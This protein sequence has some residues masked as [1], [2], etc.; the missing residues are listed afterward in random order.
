MRLLDRLSSFF[1]KANPVWKI[2]VGNTF[3]N[4]RFTKIRYD[5]L[6]KESYESN[7]VAFAS[8]N[9]FAKN[10][11]QIEFKLFRITGETKREVI[12]HPLLKLIRRPNMRQ[13]KGDFLEA[14]ASYRLLSGNPFINAV[15]VDPEN[16][17]QMPEE[18]WL[19]RPDRTKIVPGEF[20]IQGYL[21]ESNGVKKTFKCDQVTGECNILH[22]KTFHPTDDFYGLSA[23]QAGAR[24]IDI[25]NESVK[26]NMNF[27]QNGVRPSGALVYA[28]KEG[29]QVLTD[30]QFQRLEEQ[31]KVQ[32]SG[33]ANSGRPMILEG[34]MDWRQLSMSPKDIDFI[35]GKN[36]SARDIARIFGVPPLLLNIPGDNT[37]NNMKEAKLG[38]WE[39]GII[40]WAK[41][42]VDQL[43][44]WLTPRYGEDLRLELNLDNISALE[45]RRE[46]KFKKANEAAFLSYN[47][48]RKITGFDDIEGG[49]Q[50]FVPANLIPL[51]FNSATG[52]NG[53]KSIR[54]NLTIKA[55]K[56]EL[57]REQAIQL[58]LS[59]ALE[60]GFAQRMFFL[61]DGTSKRAVKEFE[62][63]GGQ[64]NAALFLREEF[65]DYTK[66]LGAHYDNTFEQFG[67][68]ILDGL[69]SMFDVL[70]TKDADGLFDVAK[71]EFV[72]TF[73][74][75]RV[76][77]LL[78]TTKIQIQTVI[79]EGTDA[80]LSI[81]KV[82]SNIRDATGGT[83]ARQ[84]A[85]TIAI[86]E[87]HTAS[88][89]GTSEAAVATGIDL[90]KVWVDS[91]DGRVRDSHRAVAISSQASPLKVSESFSVDSSKG[92]EPMRFPGDPLASAENIVRCRCVVVF[93]PVNK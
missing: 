93:E 81:G 66:L 74:V 72:N 2:I 23:V 9:L 86:T 90:N 14:L 38:L 61:I 91:N 24:N 80:G 79:D 62:K 13:G 22:W 32:Y 63:S 55:S 1:E 71:S 59:N 27:F 89:I 35:E 42:Y 36:M 84:R 56:R 20:D 92:S 52:E 7:D 10:F 87:T 54:Y 67:R 12:E 48:K 58:R 76:Q 18:L 51:S 8:I 88:Q 19:L 69:K 4:P 57:Q 39:E 78:D 41:S 73:T 15:T 60:K 43:N 53:N 21:H 5:L 16:L 75:D 17:K 47:E 68:R 82:A 11:S 28:P 64:F 77:D 29:S 45:P 65:Q 30:E 40:P 49:D 6:A 26:W 50:V 46:A 33:S 25:Y 85:L 37:Y 70:E 44:M 31:V 34:G 3:G 83:V